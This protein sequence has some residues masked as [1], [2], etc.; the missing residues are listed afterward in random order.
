VDL[1][2]GKVRWTWSS[3]Q[4]ALPFLASPSV[5]SEHV[6]IG[7]D[8]RNVYC[9]ERESGKLVWKFNTGSRVNASVVVSGGDVLTANMRGDLHILN[10][11]DGTS[12]WTYEIGSMIIGNPALSRQKFFVAASD[13]YIY[14]FGK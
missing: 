3:D 14:G 10:L 6:I 1:E 13:G 11:A 12:R 7:N 8:D 2:S 4:S 9:L 5:T